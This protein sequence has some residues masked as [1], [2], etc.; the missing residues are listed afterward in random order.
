[1]YKIQQ[2]LLVDLD[3]LPNYCLIAFTVAV[4]VVMILVTPSAFA[5]D[6]YF[7]EEKV[8]QFSN[9]TLSQV[10]NGQNYT[11]AGRSTEGIVA[12][13]LD[14]YPDWGIA[15]QTEVENGG[16]MELTLPKNIIDGFDFVDITVSDYTSAYYFESMSSNETQTIVG[17]TVPQFT[18]QLEIKG[19]HVVPE[20]DSFFVAT[21]AIAATVG[22][23]IIS[24]RTGIGDVGMILK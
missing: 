22:V 3:Q 2:Y 5:A 18:R 12:K 17:F 10:L 23:F 11:I 4:T 6:P 15:I 7:G 21:I 8:P 19:T 9:F 24:R 20:F 14:I 13:Q 1:M 16:K